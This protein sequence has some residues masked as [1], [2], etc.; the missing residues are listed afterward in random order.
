VEVGGC[1]T[2][3]LSL[4]EF[5]KGEAECQIVMNAAGVCQPWREKIRALPASGAKVM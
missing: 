5:G 1:W 2:W 4:K 3:D